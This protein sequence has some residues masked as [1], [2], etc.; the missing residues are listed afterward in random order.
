MP[1]SFPPDLQALVGEQMA[2]GK[3]ASEDELLRS[4]LRALVEEEQDLEAVRQ[5]LAEWRAGDPGLPLQDALH[6]IR[7]RH[8]L[9]EAR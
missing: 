6:A 7:Q 8:G 1:Y 2:S 4:A 5:S 9:G 3:Y